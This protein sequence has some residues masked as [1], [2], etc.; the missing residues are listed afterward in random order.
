MFCSYNCDNKEC[1]YQEIKEFIEILNTQLDRGFSLKYCPDAQKRKE[2]NADLEYSD[3]NTGDTLYIEV[4]EA[5]IGYLK[6]NQNK[7]K[8][9]DNGRADCALLVSQAIY[10]LSEEQ[11]DELQDFIVTIP[12]AF[13]SERDKI[14]FRD[15]LIIDMKGIHWDSRDS[16]SFVFYGKS[17]SVKINFDRKSDETHKIFGQQ[18][19]ILF[20]YENGNGHPSI[21]SDI[22]EQ[23]TDTNSLVEALAKNANKTGTGKFPSNNAR[24]ILLNILRM[25]L[26]NEIFLNTLLLKGYEGILIKAIEDNKQKFVSAATESYLLW[27]CDEYYQ[28]IDDISKSET[29]PVLLCIPLVRG[30]VE[31][32]TLFDLSEMC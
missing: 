17:G 1:E 7:Q 32:P 12:H 9:E 11:Q 28:I 29:K 20:A 26:G 24:K 14:P 19:S 4:K 10:D 30:F 2:Y 27:Y 18:E 6:E 22:F 3:K 23:L 21:L 25:P 15:Q 13:I 5:H 31:Q 16:Y 8:G